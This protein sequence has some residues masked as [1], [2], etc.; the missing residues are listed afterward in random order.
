MVGKPA[1]K[2]HLHPPGGAVIGLL[3]WAYHTRRV[4]IFT[5]ASA[6]G[7]TLLYFTGTR[8]AYYSAM[9][10]ALGLCFFVL[11]S[12]GRMRLCCIP[13]A[14]ALVL[15]VLFK[16]VS[17]MET[18]QTLT[19]ESFQICQEPTDEIMGEYKD[20]VYDSGEIPPG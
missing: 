8:L 17:I 7:F 12:G 3:L 1:K 10:T 20:Y 2:A 14:A 6:L 4:W 5:L 18:R 16:G 9:L 11:I 15:L 19:G 13:L